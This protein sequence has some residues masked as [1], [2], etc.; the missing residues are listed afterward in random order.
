MQLDAPR[1]DDR[2]WRSAAL[3]LGFRHAALPRSLGSRG[4]DGRR[5]GHRRIR[6]GDALANEVAILAP[7]PSVRLLAA[8]VRIARGLE[9]CMG[10]LGDNSFE[11]VEEV[12]CGQARVGAGAVEPLPYLK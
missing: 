11:L 10:Q 7:L 2:K 9:V 5:L 6:P 12:L 4:G 3:H 1:R 8:A